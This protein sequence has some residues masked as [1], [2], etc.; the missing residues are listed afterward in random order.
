MCW[1]VLLHIIYSHH[2]KHQIRFIHHLSFEWN[3]E[4]VHLGLLLKMLLVLFFVTSTECN[5]LF[6]N[7]I[8]FELF[9]VSLPQC[10]AFTQRKFQSNICRF[11]LFFARN[12]IV[13]MLCA[14]TRARFFYKSRLT[15][16]HVIFHLSDYTAQKVM[17]ECGR[18]RQLKT[19]PRFFTPRLKYCLIRSK[20][21]KNLIFWARIFATCLMSSHLV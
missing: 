19:T 12:C 13:F 5:Y 20:F 21:F 7:R 17:V 2:L 8:D 15:K 4:Q 11:L 10:G 3:F 16:N 18:E 6:V 9:R 14:P 1:F